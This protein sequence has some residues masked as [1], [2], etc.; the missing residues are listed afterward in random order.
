MPP[1]PPLPRRTALNIPVNTLSMPDMP[2]VVCFA[3]RQPVRTLT[4]MVAPQ[5]HLADRDETWRIR[6]DNVVVGKPSRDD[7]DNN[8][9]LYP[10][11]CR[12]MVRR[13]CT[14]HEPPSVA[15]RSLVNR[16]F[17]RMAPVLLAT[18]FFCIQCL[19]P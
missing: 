13:P 5:I 9:P 2:A 14:L 16:L 1:P 15:P 19:P 18:H 7:A 11:E 6:I 3:G 4:G 10:R 12:E 17:C 8:A